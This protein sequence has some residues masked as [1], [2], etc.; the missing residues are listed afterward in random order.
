MNSNIPFSEILKSIPGSLGIRLEEELPYTVVEKKGDLEIRDY[1]PF[2]LARMHMDTGFEKASEYCFRA[3]AGFIFG[4]NEQGEK[5]SMTTPVFYDDAGDGWVMSFYLPDEVKHLK[6]L[7][8][9]IKIEEMHAKRVAVVRFSGNFDQTSMNNAKD[10]LLQLVSEAG[11]KP[12]SEVW[13]AQF[14]QPMAIPALKRNEALV[15]I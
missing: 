8:L 9:S 4:N 13:W 11:L 5:T 12:Q 3:L 14:D 15:R 2:T 10:E 1:V 7:D 6:P